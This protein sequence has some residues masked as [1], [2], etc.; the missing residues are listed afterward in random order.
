MSDRL[1][2]CPE[3]G[4]DEVTVTVVT[5]YMVNT[6]EHWCHSVKSHDDN[7]EVN[8]INCGWDGFRSDLVE[9]K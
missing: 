3:C 1:L 4:S 5:K 2:V 7:A 8:C 9:D 6:L